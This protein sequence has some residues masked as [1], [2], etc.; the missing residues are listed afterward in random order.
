[1]AEPNL[2]SL[3][4][5]VLLPNG[6]EFKTW[7]P[8]LKFSKTYYVGGSATGASDDN[9]GTRAR[10]FKTIN[11]AAQVLQ[12]GER[13]VVAAGVYREWVRPKLGGTSPAKMIPPRSAR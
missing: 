9:P 6:R 4:P 3:D 8:V 10:P 11:R 7:Q 1:M 13:V 5:P 12:P 2:K